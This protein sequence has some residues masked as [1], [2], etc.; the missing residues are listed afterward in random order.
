MEADPQLFDECRKHSEGSTQQHKSWSPATLPPSIA[1]LGSTIQGSLLLTKV[2][3]ITKKPMMKRSSR[4]PRSLHRSD[5]LNDSVTSQARGC[6]A[7]EMGKIAGHGIKP[8]KM[9]HVVV[10]RAC[11]FCPCALLPDQA[12]AGRSF[13]TRGILLLSHDG[14]RLQRAETWH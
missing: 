1:R 2:L 3:R 14:Q 12:V 9:L 4:E 5:I 7:A 6:P 11:L 8:G 10:V 13:L